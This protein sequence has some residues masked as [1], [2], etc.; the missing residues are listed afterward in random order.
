MVYFIITVAVV[1]FVLSA[2]WKSG[3]NKVSSKCMSAATNVASAGEQMAKGLEVNAILNRKM[4]ELE[5]RA[6]LAERKR[7]LDAKIVNLKLDV[8]AVLAD[9]DKAVD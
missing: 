6:K 5:G 9:I 7:E 8:D 4:A 1:M 3:L 2:V